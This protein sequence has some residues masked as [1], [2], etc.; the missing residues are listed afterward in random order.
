VSSGSSSEDNFLLQL[1]GP[2]TSVVVGGGLWHAKHPGEG[3]LTTFEDNIGAL[4]GLS[5]KRNIF[6]STMLIDR[7]KRLLLFVPVLSPDYD[8][9]DED[10]NATLTPG[11]LSALNDYLL[12]PSVRQGVQILW[13]FSSHVATSDL[14]LRGKWDLFAH[15]RREEAGR[16]RS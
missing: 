4:L 5:R 8:M 12:Q 13:S 10:R 11:W 1:K 7:R 9:L 2:Q 14:G 16:H 3:Y 15:G 6:N